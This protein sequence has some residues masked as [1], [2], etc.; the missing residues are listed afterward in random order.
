[1]RQA[2]PSREP[3]D[4][5]SIGPIAYRC[6]GI[7]GPVSA[8]FINS[9]P[10]AAAI[11]WGGEGRALDHVV[12]ADGGKYEGRWEGQFLTFWTKG[13]EAT[14]T[15]PGKGDLKCSEAAAG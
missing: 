8:T 12:S 5:I 14:L 4:G 11:E 13:R 2:A 6:K 7:D 1:L 3:G 9:D 10:G 15:I